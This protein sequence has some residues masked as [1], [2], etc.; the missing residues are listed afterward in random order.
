[1]RERMSG[2]PLNTWHIREGKGKWASC[3]SPDLVN[4]PLKKRVAHKQLLGGK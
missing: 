3:R 2:D 1:M 4:K